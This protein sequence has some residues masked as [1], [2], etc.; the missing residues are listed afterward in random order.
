MKRLS[1]ILVLSLIL[2][3]PCVPS[4][5][6][7]PITYRYGA[8]FHWDCDAY[9]SPPGCETGMWEPWPPFVGGTFTLD[10]GVLVEVDGHPPGWWP[11]GS[12]T[13]GGIGD[14]T[15]VSPT[16]IHHVFKVGYGRQWEYWLRF[17]G[18]PTGSSGSPIVAGRLVRY[19]P[20]IEGIFEY[21]AVS[22]AFVPEPVPEPAS[23]LL[24]GTGL[25]GLRAWRRRGQ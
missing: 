22:L 7:D 17:D 24:L 4:A 1:C 6:A 23:L 2:T 20:R 19:D 8:S 15:E 11:P 21:G 9:D 5:Q 12:G 18:L 3:A 16:S 14:L 25:V 13:D 10:A